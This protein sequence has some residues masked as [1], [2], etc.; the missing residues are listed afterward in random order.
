M[1]RAWLLV[2]LALLPAAALGAEPQAV[3]GFAGAGQAG[4]MI[5]GLL[6]MLAVIFG[7]TALLKRVNGVQRRV[8]G[9]IKVIAAASVGAR[10][11]LLLVE[12]GGRQVLVGAAP[13]RL[14]TLLV[15]DE[16]VKVP[17]PAPAATGGF[18]ER[19]QEAVRGAS[20]EAR[21]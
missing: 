11:R 17:P 15:L 20:R 19:L 6:L 2:P 1:N 21:T 4:R 18:A 16:P 13:G 14:Q 8:P 7:L 5:A 12:V 3:P 10:E 9:A